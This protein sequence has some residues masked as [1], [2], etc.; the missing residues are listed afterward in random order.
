MAETPD[1]G[2]G[3]DWSSTAWSECDAVCGGGMQQRS[4]TQPYEETCTAH[5]IFSFNFRQVFCAMT[6]TFERVPDYLCDA[7]MKPTVEEECNT[8]PCEVLYFLHSVLGLFDK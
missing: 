2:E 4:V 7:G 8:Q 6:T 1:E 5:C 3:Y